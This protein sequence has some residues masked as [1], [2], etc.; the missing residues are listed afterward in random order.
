MT[1]KNVSL[2]EAWGLGPE[3][4]KGGLISLFA[5]LIV[6]LAYSIR[7]YNDSESRIHTLTERNIQLVRDCQERERQQNTAQLKL[8][9]DALDR[10]QVIEDKLRAAAQNLKRKR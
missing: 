8:L 6:L 1:N 7:M 9:Q 4:R 3:I 2:F 10:Q 5:I